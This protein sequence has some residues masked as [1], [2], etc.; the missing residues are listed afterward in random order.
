MR[1]LLGVKLHIIDG[2]DELIGLAKYWVKG[3]PDALG[4]RKRGNDEGGDE[5]IAETRVIAGG[6]AV[7]KVAILE[8]LDHAGEGRGG[9]KKPD[10]EADAHV[11]DVHADGGGELLPEG[12]PRGGVDV[13]ELGGRGR[14]VGLRRELGG[15]GE[16]LVRVRRA[17]DGGVGRIGHRR[18]PARPR[19]RVVG[20]LVGEAIGVVRHGGHRVGGGTGDGG[21][22]GENAGF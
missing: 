15:R 8:G 14:R 2:I 4:V 3:L 7:E 16:V 22:N 11:D 21:W 9:F 5:T 6:G 20:R 18:K 12:L 13:A 19:L 17:D 10:G 1:D